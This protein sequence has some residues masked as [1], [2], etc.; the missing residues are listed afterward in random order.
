M[1]SFPRRYYFFAGTFVITLLLYVDRICISTSKSAIGNDLELSDIQI[2]WILASFALG[3]ALFP[4]LY[5]GDS[6]IVKGLYDA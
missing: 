4:T 6:E 5:V 2:G 1:N 3:Y